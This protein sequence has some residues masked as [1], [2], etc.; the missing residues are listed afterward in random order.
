MTSIAGDS[1]DPNVP[2][3]HGSHSSTGAGVFGESEIG[4]GVH[5]VSRGTDPNQE[6]VA[7]FA[8]AVGAAVIGNSQNWIGVVGFTTSTT[9]GVGVMGQGAG[10]AT[11]VFGEADAG[12]GVHGVTNSGEAAAAITV[13]VTCLVRIQ[14][15]ELSLR[16]WDIGQYGVWGG[17]VPADRAALR[18]RKQHPSTI[19]P[20]PRP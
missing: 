10:G 18:L 1:A 11:G 8:E 13:C 3:V 4:P 2:G 16:S 12:I 15:L 14:C 5:A 20:V 6:G 17:M 7:V 19:R 9:G